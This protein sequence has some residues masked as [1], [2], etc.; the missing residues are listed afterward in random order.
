MGRET[1]GEVWDRS[2]DNPVGLRRVGG[3]STQIWDGSGYLL[4]DWDG[5]VNPLGCLR[6]VGGPSGRS[7]TG[8]KTFGRSGMGWE[9]LPE[10]GDSL[11]DLLGGQDESTDPSR[12]LGRFGDPVGGPGLVGRSSERFGTGLEVLPGVRDW[13][14]DP[15]SGLGCVG[16][17]F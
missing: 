16:R 13:S 1:L 3:P 5:S 12:G 9:T 4:K 15:F 6:Q 7:G 14:A 10:V 2:G 17:S 11:G 8:R